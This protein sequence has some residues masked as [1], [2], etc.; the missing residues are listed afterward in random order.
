[1]TFIAWSTGDA[2]DISCWGLETI[3]DTKAGT[4]TRAACLVPTCRVSP[5]VAVLPGSRPCSSHK[6]NSYTKTGV[7]GRSLEFETGDAWITLFARRTKGICGNRV[8][9]ATSKASAYL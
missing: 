1:V 5:A 6:R 2:A 4:R 3:P 9:K 8:C 7:R